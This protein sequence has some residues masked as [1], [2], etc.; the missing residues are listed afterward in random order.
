MASTTDPTALS[1]IATAKKMLEMSFRSCSRLCIIVDGLD[2]CEPRDRREISSW[3]R[4]VVQEVNAEPMNSLRCFIT[5]QDDENAR[6]NLKGFATIKMTTE[7]HADLR[8]FAAEWQRRIER[9]FGK[10]RAENR[11]LANIISARAQGMP[12]SLQD[13]V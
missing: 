9:K 3:L 12:N 4:G 8:R 6:T 1:S 10:L 11:N 7:N 5:S 13:K 2:E